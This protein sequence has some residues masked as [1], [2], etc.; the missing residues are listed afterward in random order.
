MKHD[1]A[2]LISQEQIEDLKDYYNFEEP[3]IAFMC[4]LEDFL[5]RKT[6]EKV[7]A[8]ELIAAAHRSKDT[9]YKLYG[10]K[11]KMVD[12]PCQKVCDFWGSLWTIENGKIVGRVD[13]KVFTFLLTWAE[14]FTN[15]RKM[16]L[17]QMEGNREFFQAEKSSLTKGKLEY[18]QMNRFI[19]VRYGLKGAIDS[20]L[21]SEKRT[22]AGLN[23]TAEFITREIKS[24]EKWVN[25][26]F[27]TA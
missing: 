16:I 24:L 3:D 7:N 17:Q 6:I 19:F 1:Y 5:E 26:E 23:E 4:A 25:G 11:K 21:H 27:E 13:A 9:F 15:F 20:W 22:F 14:L 8:R 10:S 12:K 2:V 18:M